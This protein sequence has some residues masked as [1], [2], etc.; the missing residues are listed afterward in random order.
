MNVSRI[1]ASLS[2]LTLAFNRSKNVNIL[3]NYTLFHTTYISNPSR[4]V[5]GW[6]KPVQSEEK[7]VR[8]HTED[9][10]GKG[11][12][13]YHDDTP[14]SDIYVS[15]VHMSRKFENLELPY[16]GAEPDRNISYLPVDHAKPSPGTRKTLIGACR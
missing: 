6:L 12:R 7:A 15:H 1:Q 9:R 5:L 3:V 11:G 2:I 10:G 8:R 14:S 16:E 4:R 13:G